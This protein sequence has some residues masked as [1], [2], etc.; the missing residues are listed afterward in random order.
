MLVATDHDISTLTAPSKKAIRPTDGILERREHGLLILSRANR[1][2][3][4]KLLYVD[5]YGG[6]AM[7]KKIKLGEVP[8]HH[9]RGCLQLIE[10]GYEVGIAE[11]ITDFYMRRNALPHDL[12]L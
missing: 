12:R 10:M 8:P 11:P 5:S 7:W 3:T 4:R 9:L 1:A 2:S 6:A